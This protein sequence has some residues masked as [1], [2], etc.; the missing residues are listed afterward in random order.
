MF[1][2]FFERSM[3]YSGK[4]RRHCIEDCLGDGQ[5][6]GKQF[7]LNVFWNEC[8]QHVVYIWVK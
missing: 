1:L 3:F 7:T 6:T 8:N 5:G 4:G 2:E